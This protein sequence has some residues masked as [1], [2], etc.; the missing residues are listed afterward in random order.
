MP[1]SIH[2]YPDGP[3]VVRG[4]V[5]IVDER[6]RELARR[7]ATISL[8]RCGRSK[9][10]P[11]CDGSHARRAAAVVEPTTDAPDARGGPRDHGSGVRAAP[12]DAAEGDGGPSADPSF[13]EPRHRVPARGRREPLGPIGPAAP[14]LGDPDEGPRG[15]T[16]GRRATA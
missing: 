1:G 7:R 12:S 5:T 14:Q 2:V 9:L 13:E 3:F 6:G 16:E 11:L 8:C 10:A 4:D 15:E